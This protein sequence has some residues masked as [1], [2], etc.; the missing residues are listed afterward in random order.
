MT[1]YD[2]PILT[3]GKQKWNDH[4]MENRAY[5]L[6]DIVTYGQKYTPNAVPVYAPKKITKEHS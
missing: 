5:A 6:V 1:K 2:R 4:Y 3:I